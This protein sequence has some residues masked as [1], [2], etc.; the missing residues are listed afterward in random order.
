MPVKAITFDAYGTLLRSDLRL[1]PER[2]VADHGLSASVED[3]LSAWITLYHQATQTTPFRTLREIEDDILP[4]VLRAFDL[5]VDAA[6]Y[7]DLFFQVTTR[8]ELYPEA[9]TVLNALDG[10]RAAVVSNAD[11]EHVAAWAFTLPVEFILISEGVQAYKPDPRMFQHALKQFGLEPHEVLHVGDS[12]VDDVRG[13]KAAGLRVAWVN[14][15]G[16]RRRPDVPQPDFEIADLTG[17]LRLL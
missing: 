16:R 15:D 11:A 5:R 7:V 6:P 17:L 9:L 2:I 4:R 13:A 8:V 10:T 14:R 12:E 3:V 1:I